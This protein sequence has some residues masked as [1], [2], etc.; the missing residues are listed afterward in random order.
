MSADAGSDHEAPRPAL[1]VH[2]LQVTLL[3]VTPLVWR[4]IR[5]PSALALSTVHAIVQ[6]AMGWEDKHLHEW[7]A[8]DVTYGLSDEDSWGEELADESGAILGEVAPLEAALHYDYD[9]SEGWEHLVEVVA[10]EA[11]NA[12]VPPV[13]LLDGARACPPEDCGGPEG[14]E[15]LI[16]ALTDPDDAEHD[17]VVLWLGD[18]FDPAELDLA[19][20][21]RRLA[22]LWQ[23]F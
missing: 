6:L 18:H 15:H 22:E 8:G 21:N 14:Y 3:D 19:L 12:D 7:R 5:V 17:E 13:A 16:D 20:V 23:T 1:T 2:E 4:R 11:W 9:L 10:V